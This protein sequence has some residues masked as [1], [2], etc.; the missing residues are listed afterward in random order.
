MATKDDDIRAALRELQREYLREL[1]GLLR[2]LAEAVSAARGGKPEHL[3]VAVSKAHAL[4]GTAGSYRFQEISDAA[5]HIEDGLVGV[6]SGW[7]PADQAWPEIERALTTAR[8]ACERA[9]V[10][11]D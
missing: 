11:D 8:A 4:R 2:G 5:G 1:P 9:R 3:R 7:L 10:E 6:Q